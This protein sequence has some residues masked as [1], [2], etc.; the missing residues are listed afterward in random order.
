MLVWEAHSALA[1][2]LGDGPRTFGA[3]AIPDGVRYPKAVRD[4]CL[5][6]AMLTVYSKALKDTAGL[7]HK[8][9]AIILETLF[10]EGI[11]PVKLA[12]LGTSGNWTVAA[13]AFT[14]SSFDVSWSGTAPN[15]PLALL[16]ANYKID[17]TSTA[18]MPIKT[19]IEASG[20]T[21]NKLAATNQ[22]DP[23]VFWNMANSFTFTAV[24]P[25]STLWTGFPGLNF[26]YLPAPTHPLSQN[27]TDKLTIDEQY[28]PTVL[29]LAELIAMKL[30][31][32]LVNADRYIPFELNLAG[33][34]NV[35]EHA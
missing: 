13:S 5:Y 7:K 35:A 14:N 23:Y 21:N 8:Q 33:V 32:D 17:A 34:G 2:S 31:Q 29:S 18:P 11:T 9:R 1:S 3:G 25:S 12:A 15:R 27:Y 16:S 22:S 28:I 4:H 6:R 10:P 19:S 30:G 20:L 24:D 26:F